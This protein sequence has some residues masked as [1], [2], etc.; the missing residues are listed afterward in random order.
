[1][2]RTKAT[3]HK[4]PESA[5][6]PPIAEKCPRSLH[7]P[8]TPGI[9]K[10]KH[11]YRPGTVALREIRRFQK[12]TRLLIRKRPF[13]CLVKESVG[14]FSNGDLRCQSAA[15]LALQEASEAYLVGLFEDM[16]LCA[17]HAKRVTIMPSD[18]RLARRIRGE[19][20]V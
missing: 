4:S 2:A 18:L 16:N 9:T 8:R 12:S 11:R 1:M 13:Q 5:G 15:I 3:S 14:K 19:T 10:K 17:L 7:L 6:R 20:K